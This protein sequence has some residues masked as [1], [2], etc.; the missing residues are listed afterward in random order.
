M[1]L[2]SEAIII[3]EEIANTQNLYKLDKE[4]LI[5]KVQRFLELISTE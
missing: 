1:N 3:Y 5:S 4:N 2:P